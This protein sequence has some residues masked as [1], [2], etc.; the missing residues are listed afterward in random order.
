MLDRLKK[1]A[2]LNNVLLIAVMVLALS[3]TWSTIGALNRNYELEQE[4]NQANLETD[5]L[6]L[7]NENL[8]LEQA[9]F[10]TDEYLELQSRSLLNRAWEGEHLVILPKAEGSADSEPDQKV[11]D[12]KSNL[13]K[14]MDFLFGPK[15]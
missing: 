12:D 11:S 15:S 7:Q 8:R 6:E 14:W 3:W 5:I 4:L 2:T 9:Y 10:Q 1:H 13:E